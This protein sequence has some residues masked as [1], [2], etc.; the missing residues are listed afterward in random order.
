MLRSKKVIAT[1]A[2]STMALA[3]CS[4]SDEVNTDNADVQTTMEEKIIIDQTGTEVTIK[5]KYHPTP[6]EIEGQR[7]IELI[8]KINKPII[9]LR[10]VLLTSSCT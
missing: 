8:E 10:V 9:M 4:Q 6:I 7:I 5:D 2:I 1:L 3:A